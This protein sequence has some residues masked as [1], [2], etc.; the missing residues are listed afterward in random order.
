[1]TRSTWKAQLRG[2]KQVLTTEQGPRV[3]VPSKARNL[4]V[5]FLVVDVPTTFNVILG[6]PTLHKVLP[7]LL[8]LGHQPLQPSMLCCGLYPSS[9]SLSHSHLFLGDLVGLRSARSSQVPRLNQVLNKVGLD[10]FLGRLIGTQRHIPS[11]L[12][13]ASVSLGARSSV[14]SRSTSRTVRGIGLIAP[15]SPAWI[16]VEASI[17]FR[18]P[19]VRWCLHTGVVFPLPDTARLQLPLVQEWRP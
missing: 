17:S 15:T 8:V 13:G 6:C 9:K 3:I 4:K 10:E 7:A 16:G 14:S 11:G 5:D 1:M 12:R 2:A 19:S 18:R